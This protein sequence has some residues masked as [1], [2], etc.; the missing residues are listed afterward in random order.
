MGIFFPEQFYQRTITIFLLGV[1]IIISLVSL[2]S[3]RMQNVGYIFGFSGIVW[4]YI[5]F[6]LLLIVFAIGT[7]EIDLFTGLRCHYILWPPLLF[8]SLL[9]CAAPIVFIF[10][11]FGN[12]W[13]NMFGHL[14][15]LFSGMIIPFLLLHIHYAKTIEKR[16]F[17]NNN[18]V[19]T[20]DNS[21]YQNEL[22]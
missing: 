18:S 6:L 5:G 22:I 10:Y 7:Y 19:F 11:L 17:P 20:E 13:T 9:T 1:P 15:G 8:T 12:H 14:A 21:K 3:G 16:Q 4:A 2:V